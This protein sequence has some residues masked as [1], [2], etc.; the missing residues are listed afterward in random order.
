MAFTPWVTSET[1]IEEVKRNISFPLSQNTFSDTDVLA[2]ANNEITDELLPN[3]LQYHE[4]FFVVTSAMR[5]ELNR[6][7]YPI[8]NRAVGMKLRDLFYGDGNQAVNLPYG[9]L[10]D[11]TRI[12]PDDKAWFSTTGVTNTQPYKFYLEGN[13]VV[14]NSTMTGAVTGYLVFTWYLRPN[15]LVL[16][17]RS[18]ILNGFS[19]T[20]TLT[21]ASIAPGDTITVN[22]YNSSISTTPYVFTAVAGAPSA[23][24]FQIGGTSTSTATNLTSAINTQITGFTASN[25]G[26]SPTNIVKVLYTNRLNSLS[27]SNALGFVLQTALNLESASAVPANIIAGGKVDLL[28]TLPGHK[29]LNYD[30]VVPTNGVSSSTLTLVDSDVP[31]TMLSGDYVCSFNECIIPQIPP[32]LHSSLAHRTCGR[33]LA[34]IGDKE[35]LATQQEHIDRIEAKESALVDN[36]VTGAAMKILNRQGLLRNSSSHRRGRF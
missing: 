10:Y 4:E 17:S 9:N 6:N 32:E 18:M 8:P 13:D 19:K 14:L 35:G 12:N 16:S 23:F 7:R 31:Q 36:R 5:L 27:V 1:L 3:L 28:Q 2:F 30:V 20:L 24:Q 15:Q 21:N 25:G 22:A 26:V 11:M 33:I 34:A 29:T